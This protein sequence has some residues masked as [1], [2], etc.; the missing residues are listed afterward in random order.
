[1]LRTVDD[2][3]HRGTES[4][5]YFSLLCAAKPRTPCPLP[6]SFRQ[7][8]MKLC[9]FV[10]LCLCVHFSFAKVR[11]TPLNVRVTRL[12]FGVGNACLMRSGGESFLIEVRD[13]RY[14]GVFFPDYSLPFFLLFLFN[15]SEN[16][17]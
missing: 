16:S 11:V 14:S 7:T 15:S 3:E 17:S 2:T 9:V 1:M 6:S 5:S 10:S 12:I 8:V 13:S 4:Q